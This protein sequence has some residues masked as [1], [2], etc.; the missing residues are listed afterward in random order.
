VTASGP[1]SESAEGALTI[2]QRDVE[3]FDEEAVKAHLARVQ[4]RERQHHKPLPVHGCP[5]ARALQLPE[6]GAMPTEERGAQAGSAL[7]NWPVQIHLLP[8]RAPFFD[9]AD[10]L[11][12]GDCLPSPWRLP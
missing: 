12:A 5:G 6:R 9:Q 7:R 11:V 10:V 1:V 3:G 2:E 8:V 4:G